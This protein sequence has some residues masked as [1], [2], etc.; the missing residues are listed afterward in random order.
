MS[1]TL[2]LT[3]LAT[4]A[5][6]ATAAPVPAAALAPAAVPAPAAAAAISTAPLP[7]VH[8][9]STTYSLTVN[10]TAVPVNG[11]AGYDYAQFSMGAGTAQLAVSRLAGGNVGSAA[12]SPLKYGHQAIRSGN[13]ATFT[14]PTAEYLI[15]TLDNLRKLVI[16]ADPAETDRPANKG[17]DIFNV[18]SS[19][20]NADPTGQTVTTAAVQ[21]ALDAA[22]AY[23]SQPTFPRGIVYVPRGVYTVGNLELRSNTSLYLEAGAVLRVSPNKSLY[24]T[25]AH[26]NSQN[27]DLTWWIQTEFGASNIKL[28][29]R[30]TLDGN[31]MA[32]AGAGFGTN[33]LVPIAASNVRLDGLTIRESG[34]WGVIPVRSNDVTFTNMKLFNRFDM[35]EADGIDVIESQNVTVRRGIGIGLDDPY[36]TKAY[37]RTVDIGVNWPG[38]PELVRDATFDGLLSWTFCY[39]FKVGQGVFSTQDTVVFK[40]G[41]VY[42]AA[43]GVG[44]HHKAGAGTAAQVTFDNI[45][46]ERLSFSND[47]RRTWL[48]FMVND[49]TGLGAGPISGVTVRNINVRDRGTTPAQLAGLSAA[50]AINDVGFDSIRMPGSTGFARTLAEL[51]ITGPTFVNRVTI[52]P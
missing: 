34:S 43:I 14:I 5:L 25:D 35:G 2:A 29:G 51:N 13:T 4:A 8:A 40:N 23:G 12:I 15:V 41:V 38:Q 46:I 26:K 42:D 6:T 22:S 3:A 37:D 20:F 1:L 28:F 33:V 19:R 18:T 17:P 47:N 50:A 39:G 24:S 52:L 31:G 7:S 9:A 10:G 21:A 49:S 36:T 30:G 27:R 11:Y 16:A 32:A 44:I 48:A 45:D